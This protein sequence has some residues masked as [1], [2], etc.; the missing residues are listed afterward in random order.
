M[1]GP[2]GWEES[3]ELPI[4]A[5]EQ[6]RRLPRRRPTHC[7]TGHVLLPAESAR[8]GGRSQVRRF[9]WACFTE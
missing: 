6:D 3:C 4:D 7:G 2:R 8:A 9:G 1:G 5:D